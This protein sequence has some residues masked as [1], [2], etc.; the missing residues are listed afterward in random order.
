MAARSLGAL[1][2]ATLMVNPGRAPHANEDDKPCFAC[3][4]VMA[5]TWYNCTDADGVRRWLHGGVG[6]RSR[7]HTDRFGQCEADG[8]T[9]WVVCTTT[10]PRPAKQPPKQKTWYNCTVPD[11]VQH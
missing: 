5:T 10:P 9:P 6:F 1:L 8:W 7:D 11:G 4:G 2:V 3:G